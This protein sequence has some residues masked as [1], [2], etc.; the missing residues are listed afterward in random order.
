MSIEHTLETQPVTP[1]HGPKK[2]KLAQRNLANNTNTAKQDATP[3]KGTE[4]KLSVLTQQIKTD[5]SRDIDM[6]RVEKIKQAIRKGELK[7]DYEKI[8]Q[9]LLQNILD[10]R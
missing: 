5:S 7:M 6:D 10:D 4:V 8:A 3:E 1:V 9:A 2:A